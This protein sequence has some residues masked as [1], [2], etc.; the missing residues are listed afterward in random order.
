[1]TQKGKVLIADL[2]HESL[3]PMLSLAGFDPVYL[4]EIKRDEIIKQ[5]PE[6]TGLVIRSKTNIDSAVLKDSAKL[7]FIARAGAGMDLIDVHYAEQRGISLINAPEGNRDAVAEHFIGLLLA[8]TH[9]IVRSNQ[10][11]KQK[12]WLREENRGTEITGKTIGILGYGFM[13]SK[14]AEKLAGFGCKVI[15]YDK[16][17]K[18]YSKS[19][20]KEVTLDE[21]KMQTEILTLHIPLTVETYHWIDY[22]FLTSMPRLQ[23]VINTARGEILVLSDLLKLLKSGKLKGASLDVLENEKF[24]TM[25][26]AQNMIFEELAKLDNVIFTPHIAGWSYE[27]YQRINEVLVEK[28]SQLHL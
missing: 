19:A 27:S 26:E 2:M 16:N 9:N 22:D 3:L 28:I 18:D 1:M 8:L 25:T 24:H 7:K 12:I 4:P 11:V 13:G 20:V 6:I 21:F 10:E 5:I 15:A 14:V 23:Y 17:K